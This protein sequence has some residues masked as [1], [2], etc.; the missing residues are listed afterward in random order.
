MWAGAAIVTAVVFGPTGLQPSDL[1]GLALHDPGVGA[2]LVLTWTLVFLPTARGI[3]RADAASF[4]RSLPGPWLA[5]R[6]IAGAAL[7]VLQLPW[8][9]LWVIGEGGRGIGIVAATTIAIA[10]LARWRPPAPRGGWPAWKRPGEAVRGIHLRALRRRAGDAL[11]RGAGFALIAGVAGG[12]FV[13]NNH[14]AD[15]RAAT[16]GTSVITIVLVPAQAGVLLVLLEA[17]RQS[18]WVAASLGIAP[19]TRIAALVFAIAI[20]NV[21]ACGIA[22]AAAAVVIG[23]DPSTLGW[24]AVTSG[25]S[26]LGSA[27][28]DARMLLA[29]EHSPSVAARVVLGTV[30]VAAVVVLWLGLLGT[31]GMFAI[32]ATAVFALLTVPA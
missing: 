5:P 29:A 21:V 26:A 14:L 28:G 16:M 3:L 32:G 24:L 27:L 17:H 15:A 25:I 4:L 11:V 10:V 18:T 22:V 20:V 30:V 13:H 1:T 6:V 2:I 31:T 7:I 8:L 9:A 19:A 23:A 12:L